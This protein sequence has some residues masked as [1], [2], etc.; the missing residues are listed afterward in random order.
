[1]YNFVEDY[2][3]QQI[4][5]PMSLTKEQEFELAKLNELFRKFESKLNDDPETS[6]LLV[7]Q[8]MMEEFPLVSPDKAH[9][10]KLADMRRSLLGKN[11]ST[12]VQKISDSGDLQI[13][14]E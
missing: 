6:E 10:Q 9:M 5:I 8:F 12:P 2:C 11:T 14:F 3:I 7:Q 13:S 4:V 1:M